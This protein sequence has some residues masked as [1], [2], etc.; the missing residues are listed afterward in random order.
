MCVVKIY[1]KC[2]AKHQTNPSEYM[3]CTSYNCKTL[4]YQLYIICTYTNNYVVD[5]KNSKQNSYN[6]WT[7]KRYMLTNDDMEYSVLAHK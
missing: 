5:N 1:T 3:Y 6:Y 7:M 4:G 2:T